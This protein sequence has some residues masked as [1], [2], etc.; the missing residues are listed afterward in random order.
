MKV[1]LTAI[2]KKTTNNITNKT[3]AGEDYS[4]MNLQNMM[5]ETVQAHDDVVYPPENYELIDESYTPFKGEKI[6]GM[7]SNNNRSS[8]IIMDNIS[9]MI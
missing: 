1:L 3:N 4:F 6:I 9:S 2:N 7:E 8:F 5:F